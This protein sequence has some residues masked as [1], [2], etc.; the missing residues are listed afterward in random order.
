MPGPGTGSPDAGQR[1]RPGMVQVPRSLIDLRDD[2]CL[3]GRGIP[4]P[5]EKAAAWS[6]ADEA[7][8]EQ[9][10]NVLCAVKGD[11]HERVRG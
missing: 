10:Q 4:T 8:R 9:A 5:F 2:G 11:D 6:E 3:S 7:S 1:L